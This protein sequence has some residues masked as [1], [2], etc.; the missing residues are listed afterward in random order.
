M[1]SSLSLCLVLLAASFIF[2]GCVYKLGRSRTKYS[3]VFIKPTLNNSP[4]AEIE[5]I[6]TSSIRKHIDET[7]N[8]RSVTLGNADAILETR[9]TNLNREIAAVQSGDVGR[10]RKFEL[11]FQVEVRLMPI[12][13]PAGEPIIQRTLTIRQDILA[14]DSQVNAERQA[15]PEIARKIGRRVA[16]ALSDTW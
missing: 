1:K 5:A 4:Y 15:G 6:A 12:N 9:I 3:G 13:A 10:G 16:E 8:I 14:G 7:G 11:Q 2:D